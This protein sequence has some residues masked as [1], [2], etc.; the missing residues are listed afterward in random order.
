MSL[1]ELTEELI[2]NEGDL[3]IVGLVDTEGNQ[4][5]YDVIFYEH[6]KKVLVYHYTLDWDDSYLPMP[7]KLKDIQIASAVMEMVR[8]FKR[9]D[10]EQVLLILDEYFDWYLD[11][12]EMLSGLPEQCEAVI[13][14]N[15]GWEHYG[16]KRRF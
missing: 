14:M 2:L 8:Y 10:V 7:V 4:V 3:H 13:T 12:L 9:I 16:S 5:Q 1:P 15:E 11:N 6:G